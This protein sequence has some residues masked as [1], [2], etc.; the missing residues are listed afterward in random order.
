[1]PPSD[2][3]SADEIQRPFADM[4]LD[5]AHPR[6]VARLAV[7]LFDG[8]RDLHGLGAD[9]RRLIWCA[10]LLHDVGYAIDWRAHNKHSLTVIMDTETPSLSPRDKK[11]VACVSRY[12]R[13]GSPKPGHPVYADLTDNQQAL[14]RKLA[15][16]LRIADGLDR[17]QIGRVAAVSVLRAGP[18]QWLMRVFGPALPVDEIWAAEK[19]SDLFREAYRAEP[20]FEY[21]GREGQASPS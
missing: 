20:H 17:G 13:K 3:P 16:I 5:F 9:E 1:M 2:L 19:K 10:G 21:A 6:N 4:G 8:M 12:H 14:V 15:A 11:V 7:A 18:G